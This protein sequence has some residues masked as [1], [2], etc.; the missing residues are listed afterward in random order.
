M[1]ENAKNFQ[2]PN[3]PPCRVLILGAG[4]TALGWLAGWFCS[5]AVSIFS[6]QLVLGALYRLVQLKKQQFIP[7]EFSTKIKNSLKNLEINDIV[8]DHVQ[9][10]VLEQ[11]SEVGGLARS[12]VD[13][14]GFCWDLGVHVMGIYF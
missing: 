4:P 9:F 11:E 6:F 2:I 10:H 3:G 7:G 14:N 1:S 12:V 13:E 8:A 5:F